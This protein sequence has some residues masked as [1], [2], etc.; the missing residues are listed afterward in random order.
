V[1]AALGL[2][3]A[4][5]A[6]ARA[7]AAAELLRA[8]LGPDPALTPLSERIATHAGGNPFFVEELVQALVE[9]GSLVGTPGAYR[10]TREIQTLALPATVQAVLAA[11]IDRLGE[12]EKQVLQTA[13]VIG[14]EFDAALLARV[15][16]LPE[17]EILAALRLLAQVELLLERSLYPDVVYGFKHP[18]TQEVALRTQLASRRAERH[19]AVARALEEITDAEQLDERAALLAGH[20][21]EAGEMLTAAR[22]RARAGTWAESRTPRG[23][24]EHWRSVRALCDALADSDEVLTLGVQARGRLIAMGLLI[25][26]PTAAL[27]RLLDEARA[28]AARGGQGLAAV[29]STYGA[30]LAFAAIDFEEAVLALDE[31][32]AL[33]EGQNDP[34]ISRLGVLRLAA[35]REAGRLDEAMQAAERLDPAAAMT[36][37]LRSF[38]HGNRGR[39]WFLLGRH[40][41]AQ[42]ELDAAIEIAQGEGYPSTVW[43]WFRVELAE[44]RG[45]HASAARDAARAIEMANPDSSLEQRAALEAHGIARAIAGDWQAAATAFASALSIGGATP[46]GNSRLAEAKLELGEQEKARELA[47]TAAAEFAHRRMPLQELST[48]C[49]LARV[50]MRAD[51]LAARES[52]EA[53]LARVEALIAQTGAVVYSPLLHIERAAL[54]KLLG[55]AL[56][57][58]DELRKAERLFREFGAPIRADAIARELAAAHADRV[59]GE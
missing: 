40:D 31:A 14:P 15:A 8:L 47:S 3:A 46:T 10:T 1:D 48:Q 38:T 20:W 4:A 56:G 45:D 33:S 41:D 11:R 9:D 42:R 53:V 44:F 59:K 27:H 37:S 19:A 57:W 50:L 28:L 5:A 49:M 30:A 34:S 43:L 26:E 39:L 16:Q 32:I 24:F 25:S 22:W 52:I 23:A 35:L 7:E 6:A 29:L 58:A 13:A 17:A 55:N 54:A 51:G 12:R 18:L 21:Q 2:P 36:M